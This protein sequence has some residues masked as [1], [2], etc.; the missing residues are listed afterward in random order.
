MLKRCIIILT[1]LVAMVPAMANASTAWWLTTK[2]I[3]TDSAAGAMVVDGTALAKINTAYLNTYADAKD[4]AVTVTPAAGYEIKRVYLNGAYVA[5]PNAAGSTF[6]VGTVSYPSNNNQNLQ[7]TLGTKAYAVTAS[8]GVGG[9]AGV[10]SAVDAS[11]AII[12]PYTKV[13]F[14]GKKVLKFSPN[15][16]ADGSYGS[17]NLTFNGSTA[18][19]VGTLVSFPDAKNALTVTVGFVNADLAVNGTF[20]SLVVDAGAPQTIIGLGDVTLNGLVA[21]SATAQNWYLVSAAPFSSYSTAVKAGT[22][23]GTSLSQVFTADK[24]G[25]YKAKLVASNAADTS[26]AYT[27]VYVAASK[28]AAVQNQCINCHNSIGMTK[29]YI[30]YGLTNISSNLYAAWSSSQHKLG[31]YAAYDFANNWCAECHTGANTGSH[32][33]AAIN[34]TFDRNGVNLCDTCHAA[35]GG[36]RAANYKNSSHANGP[37]AGR[38]EFGPNGCATCHID[39][40][41]KATM[42]DGKTDT[43]SRCHIDRRGQFPG[44]GNYSIYTS[45]SMTVGAAP[46]F[47][48]ASIADSTTA[49]GPQA[50]FMQPNATAIS[51]TCSDCHGHDNTVNPAWAD[52][53]HGDVN[54]AAWV[55][56]SGHTWLD[57][58]PSTAGVNYQTS[59]SQT[60]CIRCHTAQGFKAFVDSGFTKIDRIKVDG[61]AVGSS[62]KVSA[63]LTCNACHTSA[64]GGLR[65]AN[66][67]TASHGTK[68]YKAFYGYSGAYAS[69]RIVTTL[70]LIDNKNSNICMPCHSQRGSGQEIKDIFA[71]ATLKSYSVGASA[72]PHYAAPAAIWS[73][74]GGYEYTTAATATNFTYQDRARHQRIGNY[75]AGGATGYNNTG[76]TAGSCAFCH[77]NSDAPHSLA[78]NASTF[79]NACSKCHP[80]DFTQANLDNAAANQEAAAKLIGALLIKQGIYS[81]AT[82]TGVKNVLPERAKFDMSVQNG[83]RTGDMTVAE[84][85]VGAWVNWSLLED[86]DKGMYAHNPSYMRRMIADTI[87]WLDDGVMNDSSATAIY[88]NA[89]SAAGSSAG[90]VTLAAQVA[91]SLTDPGCLGCHFGTGPNYADGTAIPGIEQ[92]KHFANAATTDAS[93]VGP[94]MQ[95]NNCHGY[96]HGTDSPSY[97]FTNVA[98]TAVYPTFTT[99]SILK[100]FA[101]QGHADTT[102][103][104][105]DNV[106]D[107]K[108]QNTCNACHTTT[109][110]VQAV[111]SNW[112]KT[113]AWGSKADKTEQIIACNACHS[114]TSTG[115]WPVRTISGGYTAGMGGYGSAA[116]TS[117]V[118][119]DMGTSNVCIPCHATRENGKSIILSVSNFSNASFKNPHYLGAAAVFYGKGGFQF[120]S[121]ASQTIYAPQ[122]YTTKYG[123][124]VDGTIVTTAAAV[125]PAAGKNTLPAL[126]IGDAAVGIRANWSHG[127]LGMNNYSTAAVT[128]DVAVLGT[129]KDNTGH[130]RGT[131]SDGQ[132]V[133][134]HMGPSNKH[135]FGA[136][137]AAKSTWGS[138]SAQVNKGCYGC[139]VGE[140]MEE[141]AVGERA[142]VDRTLAFFKWQLKQVGAEYSDAYPY[143]YVP[144][145]TTAMKNW[146]GLTV[147]NGTGAANMGAAMNLKMLIAEPGSHVHN[148]TFMKQLIFDS[149][150]Y[151]QTGAV[152]FSNRNIAGGAADP[153]GLISFSAYSTAVTPAGGGLPTDIATGVS[154]DTVSVSQLKGYITRKNTSGATGGTAIA[155]VYTRP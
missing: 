102:S 87:D 88:A 26:T 114:G 13:P 8:G 150:Q 70:Q 54:G 143:F 46:H 23:I 27:T 78:I 76:T 108:N 44:A 107:F 113:T 91:K 110:Y 151:L 124:V 105:F 30:K 86:F 133:A 81:T 74:K 131:G 140:D 137:D 14:G 141:V 134:C 77:M 130:I 35:Y 32:P 39:H 90:G 2:L 33:G 47:A 56:N 145:T 89:S 24:F 125:A 135:T 57:Q 142:L 127:K 116:K 28:D 43:C 19:P 106:E 6:K 92:P 112:T 123:V 67:T 75:A 152:S 85:N 66:F 34:K 117:V 29:Q 129:S 22:S 18:V 115:I 103:A 94:N 119:E 120:Y 65:L 5:V 128:T 104:V 10:V 42:A 84:K 149:V 83:V 3:A 144:G 48:P 138:A 71:N 148:R 21:G 111:N 100:D 53:G 49:F 147:T 96:G 153:N 31:T 155:P 62:V 79:T 38:A 154:G 9:T 98:K 1:L 82:A 73:G 7:V 118:Y 11:G 58:G 136:F 68:G 101:E 126:N 99:A 37:D 55:S 69:K 20:T 95:C 40:T 16:K 52:G 93:Y 25:T 12:G 109:G 15:K 50:Y 121:S 4:V 41:F 80:S 146:A 63:P 60:N 122:A 17:V 45:A 36:P 132:C 61:S 64:E 51:A 97:K 59:P 139:H 72:Y